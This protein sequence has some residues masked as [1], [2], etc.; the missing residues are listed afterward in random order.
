MRIADLR[1]RLRSLGAKPKHEERV[2]RLWANAL[3]QTHGRRRIEDWLP[4]EL[5]EALP[6]LEAELAGLATL[7]S[8]HAGG[9]GSERLLVTL[10][11]GQTVESVLLPR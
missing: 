9:D 11:D 10:A 4:L 2:L 6:A 1:H 3:P 7:R 5:R 8:A